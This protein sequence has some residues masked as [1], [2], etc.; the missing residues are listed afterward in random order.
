MFNCNHSKHKNRKVLMKADPGMGKTTLGK[1]VTRDWAT[2]V[3]NKFSIVFFVALKFVKP[4]DS[5]EA[6]IIQQHPELEGLHITQQKL[7]TLLNRNNN[8]ILLILD[9]LDEY[10]GQ[11]EDVH[12]MIKNQKLLDC[13]IVVSSRPHSVNEVELHFP[14]IVRVEGF[15]VKAASKFVPKVFVDKTKIVQILQFKPSDSREHF[16]V[17]KCQILLSFLCLLARE[18]E[19]D[20]LDRNL[21][22]GHLY[23]RMVQCLYKKFTMRKGVPFENNEFLHVLKSV[24][25]LALQT[26]KV[27]S[28]L[29]QRNEVRRIA[30]NFAFEYG[31]FAGQQDF[32][33]CT[34]PAADTFVTY[35]HRSI[36][37]FFWSFGL[38]QALNDGKSVEEI[39]G[40]ESENPMLLVN[41]L[42]LSFCLWLLKTEFFTSRRIV[43][44]KLAAYTARRIDFYMLNTM[45]KRYFQR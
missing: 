36:D 33:L 22:I 34:D 30:G 17:H 6:V 35:A 38:I 28:S 9:G 8:R 16:P 3:F 23:L 12:K 4:G 2:G 13:G 10:G 44:N 15:T 41:P 39:L 18:D 21:A 26:I 5:I 37:E 45:L 31:F 14:T 40:P 1:K 24:G 42:I 29:L 32:K 43:F 11:N 27:N 7:K 25:H 19:M 20:M